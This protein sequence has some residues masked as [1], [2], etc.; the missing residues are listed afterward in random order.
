MRMASGRGRGHLCWGPLI[1]KS[2]PAKGS[3]ASCR[4]T[5]D[6]RKKGN[7]SP[8]IEEMIRVIVNRMK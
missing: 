8:H 4:T 3:P 1:F 6:K 7:I 5:P 2:R